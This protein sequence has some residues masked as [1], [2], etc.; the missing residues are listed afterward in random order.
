[1]NLKMQDCT[2]G[3]FDIFIQYLQGLVLHLPT[4][5]AK[6]ELAKHWKV[7]CLPNASW[8]RQLDANEYKVMPLQNLSL[9]TVHIAWVA[10]V[11]AWPRRVK[12]YH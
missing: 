8:L 7:K 12:G 11:K 6:R 10:R 1:M 4:F 5:I 3:S 2:S 9:A